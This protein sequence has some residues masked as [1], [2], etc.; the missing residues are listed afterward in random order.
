VLAEGAQPDEVLR[1]SF[2]SGIELS[3]FER[4][5]PGLRDVFIKLV[6]GNEAEA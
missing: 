6:G 1:A 2:R 3:S 4:R 5:D